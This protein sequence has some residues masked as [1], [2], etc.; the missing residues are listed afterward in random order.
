MKDNYYL[1]IFV[2]S[3]G[4]LFINPSYSQKIGVINDEVLMKYREDYLIHS[5]KIILDIA[6][7]K[8]L[9]AVIHTNC[10]IWITSDKNQIDITE[11]LLNSLKSNENTF[12]KIK[13]QKFNG[14]NVSAINSVFKSLLKIKA[15][16]E[17]G[18]SFSLYG[19]KIV[20]TKGEV[21]VNM[22]DIPD[23]LIKDELQKSMDAY[24]DALSIWND[25]IQYEYI[26]I[27]EKLPIIKKY[28]V[29]LLK[30][31]DEFQKVNDILDNRSLILNQIWIAGQNY[32]KNAENFYK[33]TD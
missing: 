22:I 7:K 2:L 3:F 32:L 4:P 29:E 12:P 25:C 33:E 19:E 21:A 31:S 11:E 16:T 10:L 9:S 1:I 5:N 17:V 23:G 30:T 18:V 8:K 27:I 26:S 20:E 15:A 6:K 24:S 13:R 14:E 28:K